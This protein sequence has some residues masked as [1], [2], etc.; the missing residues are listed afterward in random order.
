VSTGRLESFSD[1]VIAV[2][3]TLLVLNITVPD[4][5]KLAQ[6]HLTLA[7]ALAQQ[8]PIYAAYATSFLT[9]GIIWINHHAMISR[10]ARADHSIL[11]LNL[12][13]LL[14]IGVIPFGTS[15]LA[16]YLKQG[17]GEH[18]AAAI[19]GGVLL[20]M[21]FAFATLNRQIL[22]SRAHLMRVELALEQR[23]MIL[24]RSLTGI[25]PYVLATALA[26]VSPYATLAICAAIA[27]FYAL[28]IASGVETS[29]RS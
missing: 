24:Y 18:L 25:A 23:Q 14:T 19:Y 21:S 13:L 10:L 3:A 6:Q 20:M 9:I 28:P 4:P 22:L 1:G 15:L 17:H 11:M 8:W 26:P 7:H 12:L 29:A 5:A 2:A 16:T 27:V